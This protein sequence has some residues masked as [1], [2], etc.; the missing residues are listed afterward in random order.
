MAVHWIVCCSSVLCV[1]AHGVLVVACYAVQRV[2]C[3]WWRVMPYS[4]WS[5]YCSVLSI[6]AHGVLI[7]VY[8][9]LQL[10]NT[11]QY[12]HDAKSHTIAQISHRSI[13]LSTFAHIT[14]TTQS[15][16]HN[17]IPLLLRLYPPSQP[18]HTMETHIIPSF[19]F[20]RLSTLT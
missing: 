18:F 9:P 16:P 7:V 5:A 19:L 17:P 20:A 10:M 11:Y 6:T 1:V 3:L 4:A 8:Y 2:E 12:P 15:S 14:S 13:L